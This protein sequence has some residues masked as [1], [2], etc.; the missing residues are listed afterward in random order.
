MSADVR[1]KRYAELAVRVG[2]NVQPGQEVMVR[3]MIEHHEL[4]RA[5]VEAAYEAGA[6]YV[7]IHY[8]DPVQKLHRLNHAEMD[9][10]D[11]VPAWWDKAMNDLAENEGAVISI[12]GDPVP[13]LFADIPAEKMRLDHMPSTPSMLKMVL[14]GRVNWTIVGGPIPEWAERL[15]GE[16]DTERLWDLMAQAT[17]LDHDDPV[18]AWRDHVAG[19]RERAQGLQARTFTALR[20]RGPGTD[21][22]IGL[23][24]GTRWLSGSMTTSAGIE[25]VANM[26]T[27]E[28]FTTPDYRKT[29]GTVRCTRPLYLNGT[30]VEGLELTFKEGEIVE[31]KADR[32][33]QAVEADIS[34]DAGARRLGEVALVDGTSEVGK[35]GVV[36]GNTLF[37]ENAT[38]HIAWGAGFSNAVE[39]LP[40]SPEERD[41]VGFNSSTTHTDTMIGGPE[42]AVHGVEQGGTE[43][44]V[45]ID[46]EWQLA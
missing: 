10:L 29:E 26:P 7:H 46:N 19:L 43:V 18:K 12:T 24:E 21:L 32:N 41:R 25:H 45:I 35:T 11:Y 9:S 44:P 13:D 30:I 14:G 39:G 1:L 34:T 8:W 38:C 16:P 5:V 42:V 15:F 6:H 23:H 2:A 36:F 40:E 33:A 17:R 28:V 22:T 27:E 37:D 4:A 31:V 3:G 20:Y